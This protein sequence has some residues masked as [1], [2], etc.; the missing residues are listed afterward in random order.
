MRW[1]Y[2]IFPLASSVLFGCAG[3]KLVVRDTPRSLGLNW[4]RSD[5]RFC[6][7]A[8][9]ASPTPKTVLLVPPPPVIEPAALLPQQPVLTVMKT[10]TISVPFKFASASVTDEANRIIRREVGQPLPGDSI[11]V[12]GR[13]DDLGSQTFNDRLARKRAEAVVATLKHF[14]FKGEIEVHSQG[15]CCY[16]TANRSEESRAKNRRVDLQISTTQ[17]E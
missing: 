17:K 13:T 1:R 6:E 11:R 2:L 5:W 8:K 3:D 16:S 9:C 12:E 10:R 14:G 7:A 15:K 4:D